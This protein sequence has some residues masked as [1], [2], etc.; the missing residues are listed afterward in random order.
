MGNLVKMHLDAKRGRMDISDVGKEA[1]IY[2]NEPPL[3]KS[4][5]LRR[6]MMD[7]IFG[8]WKWRFTNIAKKSRFSCYKETQDGRKTAIFQ[9]NHKI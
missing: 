9:L 7:K 5:R 1:M 3:S 4:D 8:R 6:S 2:W